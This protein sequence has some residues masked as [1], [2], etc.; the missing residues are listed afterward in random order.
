MCTSFGIG[1]KATATGAVMVSHSV[2]GWYDHQLNYIAGGDFEQGAKEE[3]FGDT[4]TAT[5]VELPVR[6]LGEIDQVSHTNGYF[7]IGYPFLNEKGLTIGEHT[8]VGRDELVCE[9]GLFYIAN[10]QILG[11]KRTTKAKECVQLMGDLAVKHGYRDVGECLIVGDEEEVWVLEICGPGKDWTP[12]SGKPGAYW[13]ARRLP[14]DCFFV[15][16]NR[17]RMGVV[18]FDAPESEQ[19]MGPG[20]R[21]FAAG[22]GWWKEGEEFNFTTLF[23]PKSKG[24]TYYASRREWR[25]LSLLAPS[26]DWKPVD[27]QIA[28]PQFVRPDEPITVQKMIALYADHYE[29]TPFD[30]TQGP[31]AGPFHNPTRWSQEQDKLPEDMKGLDWERPIAIFRCSYSFI[32]EVRSWLPEPIRTCLWI[33]LDAQDTTV[34]TPLYNGTRDIPESWTTSDQTHYSRESCWW[35][36][37]LVRNWACLRWDAMYEEIK[38]QKA[39]LENAFFTRQP[40]IEAGIVAAF[41]KDPI[42]ARKMACRYSEDRMRQVFTTW[43]DFGDYLISRYHNGMRLTDE[44]ARFNPGYPADW[45]KTTDFG[46]HISQRNTDVSSDMPW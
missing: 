27:D 23:D 20:M 5:R 18:D 3:I 46:D 24:H 11:L 9:K 43:R 16:A 7:H 17:S 4:C 35:A 36:F 19:I 13:I 29:G 38:E 25:A 30:L 37:N 14:D 32:A 2:D 31:A 41:E 1:K 34:Y 22:Q 42:L 12:E 44:G 6:K 45:L 21:E 8:W 10:L 15:G 26:G 28:Y 39:E 33:G 40:F